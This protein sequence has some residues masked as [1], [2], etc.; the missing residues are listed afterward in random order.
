MK[1]PNRRSL[2]ILSGGQDSVTALGWALRQFGHVDAVSF[3]YGQRHS[4]ELNFAAQVAAYYGVRHKVVNIPFFG[5][6]VPSA[7]TGAGD[8]SVPHTLLK[9]VPNSFV[10]N[11]NALFLTLAHAYA[12]TLEADA[13]VGG[14]CQT[15]FSGYPDCRE[16]FIDAF[17]DALNKGS[18]AKIVPY[19]PLMYLDKAQTFAL[20][21][22]LGVLQQV[23]HSHTCYEGD[24]TAQVWGHGC[25]Q[26]PA[27]TLRAKGWERFTASDYDP[28]PV[29]VALNG[30]YNPNPNIL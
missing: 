9:G 23:M 30:L 26:C 15:D 10:P 5:E 4:V 1:D 3:N 6:L 18:N 17:I 14:M 27:C 25:G 24:L 13:L 12:Q 16:A 8:V 7:L 29:D 19:M 11:R 28:D 22:L 21:N 2:V 20:A